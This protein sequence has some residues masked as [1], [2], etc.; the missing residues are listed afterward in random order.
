[1]H[2][3]RK[4]VGSSVYS[5]VHNKDW[6]PTY[7]KYSSYD[8]RI[9]KIIRIEDSSIFMEKL[10]GFTLDNKK[11]LAKLDA[12]EKRFIIN[13][14]FDIYNKQFNFK[15]S[16]LGPSDV[17]A[18]GDF[19]MQNLMYCNGKVKLIDPEEFDKRSLKVKQNSMRYGKFFET[20]IDL[21]CLV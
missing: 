7:N 1:M 11:E 20:Y 9:V 13:E 3:Y 12:E 15:D 5:Q 10:E 19:C 4:R 2:E 8:P 21:C 17:W 16:T 14:V 18:H 6:L